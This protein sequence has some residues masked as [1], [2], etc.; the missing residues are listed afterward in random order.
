MTKKITGLLSVLLLYCISGISGMAQPKI[1]EQSFEDLVDY[2]NCKYTQAYIETVR[3]IPK[4]KVNIKKYDDSIKPKL[5]N[6]TISNPIKFEYLSRLLKAN[7]WSDTEKNLFA[8]INERKNQFDKL[9]ECDQ[10][11]DLLLKLDGPFDEKLKSVTSELRQELIKQFCASGNV[12]VA[13]PPKQNRDSGSAVK[14]GQKNDFG[15]SK[16]LLLLIVIIIVLAA[17]NI[18]VSLVL[19]QR[20]KTSSTANYR[21]I[22]DI[23]KQNLTSIEGIKS[24]LQRLDQKLTSVEGK[25]QPS[26]EKLQQSGQQTEQCQP[27]S[28]DKPI[29]AHE[30]IED[31]PAN[32]NVKYIKLKAGVYLSQ[33]SDSKNDDCRFRLFDINGNIAK[34][35]FCGDEQE[36]IVNKNAFFDKVCEDINYTGYAKHIEN[37]APGEVQRQ[38]DGRWQVVKKAT[39]RFI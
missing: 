23:L 17:G 21:N 4:E 5:A 31:V 12:Q 35:E 34:F 26:G 8:K 1:D 6:N 32:S 9:L 7:G 19:W 39:I 38:S 37:L 14:S 27:P 11:I 13:G 20:I 15:N 16:L 3:N 30:P 36:A 28:N 2:V 10:Q 33:E 25:I 18:A 24:I 22:K 29:I